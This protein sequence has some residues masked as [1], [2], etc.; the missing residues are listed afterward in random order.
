MKFRL[1]D[2]AQTASWESTGGPQTRRA[3]F[4]TDTVSFASFKIDRMSLK[5][6]RTNNDLFVEALKLP[7]IEY[8]QCSVVVTKAQ[9]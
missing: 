1:D 2:A 5:L 3:I 8:A 4:T 6:S 7:P 9:F